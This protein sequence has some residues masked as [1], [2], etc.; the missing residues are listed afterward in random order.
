MSNI[1]VRK[2]P[3]ATVEHLPTSTRG[4]SPLMVDAST[5][6]TSIQ[7]GPLILPVGGKGKGNI[8][9]TQRD[10]THLSRDRPAFRNIEQMHKPKG[11]DYWPQNKPIAANVADAQSNVGVVSDMGRRK[12]LARGAKRD[13]LARLASKL[14]SGYA[15]LASTQNSDNLMDA[16]SR[17]YGTY[18]G[19][20]SLTGE[21]ALEGTYNQDEEGNI[22][23]T[24]SA[25]ERGFGDLRE[26]TQETGSA[27]G[28]GMGRAKD[29]AKEKWGQFKNRWPTRETS[30]VAVEPPRNMYERIDELPSRDYHSGA[31]TDFARQNPDVPL[32]NQQVAVQRT[33]RSPEHSL[34]VLQPN[35]QTAVLPPVGP[36]DVGM[37][38]QNKPVEP[39][40]VTANTG[41]HTDKPAPMAQP[42]Q[43]PPSG[44]GTLDPWTN[45]NQQNTTA[46]GGDEN[47]PFAG[48]QWKGEPMDMAWELLKGAR[49]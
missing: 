31:L 49:V 38:G 7:A 5:G 18:L 34:P 11:A 22:T 44:Q 47:D 6:Q 27:I 46:V 3:E 19:G 26:G 48:V 39:R 24:P 12:E 21:G 15:A 8:Q 4:P 28:R 42:T 40:P 43:Q 2:G 1:L 45:P 36:T 33:P 13:K 10:L 41:T 25:F 35:R 20:R 9:P 32:L 29:W 16:G 37:T 23:R 30:S 17:A 14:G